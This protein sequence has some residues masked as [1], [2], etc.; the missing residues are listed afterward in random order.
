MRAILRERL[1]VA[2]LLGG[3]LNAF[4]QEW[5]RFRGPN[6]TGLSQAKTIPAQWTDKDFNWKVPLPGIGHSSPVLWGENI[7]LTSADA[8]AGQVMVLRLRAG[9]GSVA[10][11]KGFPFSKFRK[12]DYNSFASCTP[13]VDEHR[14]YVC[15]SSPE[16]YVLM[17]LSHEGERIW[18]KNLG[19]FTSQHGSG[20]SPIVYQN[21]VVLADEQDGESFLIA[22]DAASGKTLWKAP[23]K[24]TQ[25]A[26]G[27]PCVYEPKDGPPELIFNSQS[28]G[29]SAI[30]P[31]NGKELW[32]FSKAFDKRTVSSPV[33]AGDLI[34]GSCGSGG[35]GNFIVAVRPGEPG[36]N[37]PPELAYTIRRSA[38][39][40]PTSICVGDLL[41]LW[42]D[43]GIVSCVKAAS[44]EIKWQ[45]RVG[46]DFFGSPV[47]VD[48]RL[49]CVS[50]RGEVVV[51]EASERFNLL[52]KNALEEQTHSTP[53]VAGGRMY[54]HTSKHLVSIGGKK[55]LSAA[56]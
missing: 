18:E 53:A 33:I 41:F 40:V 45:E 17:A 3:A 32:E 34:I 10:W 13:A 52:A 35:G 26:Y 31:G 36:K 51:V 47:C 24:T 30:D 38:P 29:I 9:D 39:Y 6:G 48:G 49:F 5:S 1:A 11:Q 20:T 55:V 37:K 4:G 42:G 22:V 25:T 27:T 43:G 15:W 23:R 44:G 2:I 12:H 46:G 50:A 8:E 7:F 54:I 19:T 28:H 21:K 56:E 14:V 16:R